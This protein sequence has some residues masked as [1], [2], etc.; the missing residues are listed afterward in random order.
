MAVSRVVTGRRAVWLVV[1]GWLIL[2]GALSPLQKKLPGVESNDTTAFLPASAESTEVDHLLRDRF[3][4]GR[5]LPALLVYQRPGGL[6]TADWTA[7]AAD[8]ARAGRVGN[9]GEP[10]LPAPAGGS[11]GGLVST[12]RSVAVVVLPITQTAGA[13]VRD[14]VADVRDALHPPDGLRVL[15]TGPAGISADA[16]TV[17]TSVDLKL[18]GATIVLVLVLLLIIYRS[19][20]LA[21]VPLVCVAF[22]YV[23]A[24]ALVYLLADRAGLLVNNQATSLT[25][26]L[27][28]GAGTDYSLL[29]IA[30]YREELRREPDQRVALRAALRAAGP[31]ILSSGLTVLAAL[32]VLLVARLGSTR[33][34]GPVGAIGLACVLI[35]TFTLLPALLALLGRRAFWPF[36]GQVAHRPSV[37]PEA[38]GRWG[39]LGAAVLRRP[40]S[41]VVLVLLLFGIATTGLTRYVED[42]NLLDA[43]RASTGSAAGYDVLRANFPAG[44]LAPSTVVAER[45]AGELTDADVTATVRRIRQLPGIAAVTP[46]GRSTDGRAARISVVLTDDPYAQAGLQRV[47][48]LRTA[49]ATGLPAGVRA[50]VGGDPAVQYDG[51]LTA[52]RDLR[53]IIPLTLAVILLILVVVLRALVA[54]L[55]LIATVIVSFFGAFGLSVAVFRDLA[56]QP[57]IHPVEPTFAFLFLVALGVDYNIFLMARVRE[58]AGRHGT[59]GGILTG[60][61]ATGG[62][63]TSAGVVLAG[64]FAVLMTLPLTML[65]Q[66]GFTVAVGVLLD[67]FLVRTVLVPAITGLLGDRAWWPGRVHSRTAAPTKSPAEIPEG[68]R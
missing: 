7:V 24:T 9:T 38:A 10:V 1:A 17:F 23:L 15:V 66:L 41:A 11:G 47:G 6:T 5:S 26:I 42:V 13:G 57:G 37:P 19:P 54:P 55:Y 31:S 45:D 25:L 63:I 3:P 30:R 61:A 29:L 51:K 68:S 60:L 46:Q 18:L 49:L 39:R 36:T 4:D 14:T 32:C 21:V 56:G 44:I 34:L 58:E 20:L 33:V 8:A 40:V 62:V 53:H 50:L 64:T 43:F 48:D 12:D 35:S 27:M 59:R 28:F 2:A 16:I 67:T 22:A 65:F 52:E